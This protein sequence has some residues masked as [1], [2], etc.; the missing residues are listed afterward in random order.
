MSYLKKGFAVLLCVC[1]LLSSSG[2]KNSIG[3]KKAI[4]NRIATFE[5]SCDN[6]DLKGVINCFDPQDTLAIKIVLVGLGIIDNKDETVFEAGKRQFF[7]LVTKLTNIPALLAEPEDEDVFDAIL[8]SIK[9]E[10]DEISFPSRRHDIAVANC[11]VII[12]I[13][14]ESYSSRVEFDMIKSD[15][16]WYIDWNL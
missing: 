6:L 9:V 2:C 14:E 15:G 8:R 4:S 3:D 13:G 12:Q 10:A 5:K 11:T 1:L 7:E 16:E